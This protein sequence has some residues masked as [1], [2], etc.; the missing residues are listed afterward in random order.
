MRGQNWHRRDVQRKLPFMGEFAAK[1]VEE[2][3][4]LFNVVSRL[5][6]D[7]KSLAKF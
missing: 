2:A 4:Y 6:L 3:G 1:V 5:P 7:A